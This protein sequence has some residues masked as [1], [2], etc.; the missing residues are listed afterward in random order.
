MYFDRTVAEWSS[1]S[2][3]S[4]S[5]EHVKVGKRQINLQEGDSAKLW[6]GK[7]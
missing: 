3:N 5:V 4:D 7:R 1:Y 6:D 2:L